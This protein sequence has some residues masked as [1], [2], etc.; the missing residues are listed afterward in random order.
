MYFNVVIHAILTP[1]LMPAMFYHVL[2]I[3]FKVLSSQR[4]SLAIWL[5]TLQKHQS[6]QNQIYICLQL[7]HTPFLQT[8]PWS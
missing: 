2:I 1:I 3:L 5:L 6:I 7:L 8:L 4:V